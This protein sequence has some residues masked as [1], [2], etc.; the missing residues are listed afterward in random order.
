M[1]FH[2]A[3]RLISR[4]QVILRVERTSEEYSASGLITD[5]ILPDENISVAVYESRDCYRDLQ[6]LI[7]SF[8]GISSDV[9]PYLYGGQTLS[10]DQ[11][12]TLQVE[13]QSNFFFAL[14]NEE[15]NDFVIVRIIQH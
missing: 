6:P 4:I 8:E 5:Y 7:R 9:N 11:R 10:A 14:H 15:L 1:N 3:Q 12:L 13:G 2:V